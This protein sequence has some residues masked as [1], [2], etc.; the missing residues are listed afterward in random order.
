M[1]TMSTDVNIRTVNVQAYRSVSRSYNTLSFI[2]I[3]LL[4]LFIS[5]QYV[6]TISIIPN[7]TT[8][9]GGNVLYIT[10]LPLLTSTDTLSCVYESSIYTLA[11]YINNTIITCIVP[12]GLSPG[13][14]SIEI[15]DNYNN[16][17]IRHTTQYITV[18]NDID[19]N[20]RSIQPIT[21]SPYTATS[22]TIT[23]SNF[24]TTNNVYCVF[25]T[26][27]VLAN[28]LNNTL[29]T[30]NAPP[31]T[32]L[33]ITD[34]TQLVQITV[35]QYSID[36]LVVVSDTTLQYS[37][38]QPIIHY[39]TP[40]LISTDG[41]TPVYIT[42]NYYTYNTN[43]QCQFNQYSV[44][45]AIYNDTALL[46]MA[47]M[48][49]LT[50][51][52]LDDPQVQLLLAYDTTGLSTTF[53][54]LLYTAP[55]IID[56]FIP[57]AGYSESVT[58]SGSGF[59]DTVT[60]QCKLHATSYTNI[61][62]ITVKAQYISNSAIICCIPILPPDSITLSITN[63][64][65]DYVD[66]M[67]QYIYLQSMNIISLTPNQG[68]ST[69]G[70]LITVSGNQ[71]VNTVQLQCNFGA[72]GTIATYINSTTLTCTT[73]VATQST[74]VLFSISTLSSSYTTNQLNYTYHTAAIIYNVQPTSTSFIDTSLMLTLTGVNFIN[75]VDLCCVFG[76]IQ[77]NYT[78]YINS[79]TIQCMTPS[80]S[81]PQ[82][83]PITVQPN[84]YFTSPIDMFTYLDI[85]TIT[86]IHP[87]HT[88]MTSG[89]TIV[90][91]NGY[92]FA[93]LAAAL[94]Q[95]VFGIQA[96][97][98]VWL[99]T[100]QLLCTAPLSAISGDVPFNVVL[101]NGSTTASTTQ[102]LY[103]TYDNDIGVQYIVPST[104][105]YNIP[106]LVT[107]V[108]SNYYNTTTFTCLFG[109]TTVVPALY[110]NSTAI[111]C[112]APIRSQIQDM[113]TIETI[114]TYSTTVSISDND[115]TYYQTLNNLTYT[116]QCPPGYVC[117]ILQLNNYNPTLIQPYL[118]PAGSYCMGDYRSYLCPPG[119]YQSQQG[120]TSC[121]VCPLSYICPNTGMTQPQLC[122]AGSVCDT[123]GSTN[124][125]IQ[126]CPAGYVCNSG[127]ISEQAIITSSY[128]IQHYHKFH[129]TSVSPQTSQSNDLYDVISQ[130]PLYGSHRIQYII[131]QLNN[132]LSSQ[133]PQPCTP[134]TF[135]LPGS[136]SLNQSL[137]CYAAHLCPLAS[138]T[139]YG[140]GA[141]ST[142]YYCPQPNM[143]LIC[144]TGTYCLPGQTE[145]TPCLP[146]TYQ[147]LTGQSNCTECPLGTYCPT[148]NMSH[149]LLCPAGYVCNTT[150]IVTPINLC[151]AG[152]ICTNGTSS[153]NT[154]TMQLCPS[155]TFCL[156]GVGSN[157]TLYGSF[158]HPQPCTAGTYCDTG[159]SGF[160]GTALCPIGSVCPSGSSSDNQVT[161]GEYTG[162]T[163]T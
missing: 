51:N 95:C 141:C 110:V 41:N 71:F 121:V 157:I 109:L 42:G 135:C 117:P 11:T 27:G 162:I 34:P 32:A 72:Q 35:Q 69:G 39:I 106:A 114:N 66:S 75:A 38:M 16:S 83:V 128:T 148:Y 156:S 90:T 44:P 139:P 108:G 63:N 120:Q 37:Y 107:V 124:S 70:T 33:Y 19:I 4:L 158:D 136:T 91:V 86:D 133:L 93:T 30:C 7:V 127:I 111:T 5:I 45:A 138:T 20:I 150:S 103:F 46:C 140:T 18:Y 116:T 102:L 50:G 40:S 159:A 100:Q 82:S 115:S 104:I 52:Q 62:N 25:N 112:I 92:N 14:N 60:L 29:L 15:Y 23:G 134:N 99:N 2:Y 155:T 17:I 59:I 55:V 43:I 49:T 154:T 131:N 80:L 57:N 53:G 137:P 13:N 65:Y 9:S 73:P 56:S 119:S 47:P 1:I 8:T 105:Q 85:P 74:T 96:V 142:G 122:P 113:S 26:H 144:P 129:L 58:I 163:N 54:T 97:H 132:S 89:S 98:A 101:A 160:G 22:I 3:S 36:G 153:Y 118:C 151:P 84:T 145:P 21:G 143:Q 146:G 10:N 28:V 123:L 12:Y 130:L 125:T 126:P 61:P 64:G 77:S 24:D 79:T 147:S 68:Q 87:V 149:Y 76:T 152:H 161:I 78:Q 81:T 6:D 67:Q 31:M 48:F 88:T 94:Y